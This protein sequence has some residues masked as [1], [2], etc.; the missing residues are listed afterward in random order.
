VRALVVHPGPSFSVHDVWRGWCRGLA[1]NGVETR[2]FRLDDRITFYNYLAVQVEGEQQALSEELCL[3]LVAEDLRAC[4][5]AW[6]PDLVLIV[7]GFF[8][9]HD[10]LD[11]IRH[12]HRHVV[13]LGTESPYE[14]ERQLRDAQHVDLTLV[15][16]PTN[17]DEFRAVGPAEYQPHCYDPTVHRPGPVDPE[18]RSDVA[19][20]GTG[21]PSR[22]AF[23]EQVGFGDLDVLLAGNWTDLPDTSPLHRYLATE[24]EFC[25]DNDDTVRI[26]RSTTVGLN[27][28]RR[29]MT[30]IVGD[31]VG[32]CDGWSMGPR[33]VEL[34]ATGRFFL[35]D[36]RPEGDEVFPFLP[37]F[38]TPA[39]L[40]ELCHHWAARP[41][42]ADE[43]GAK[44]AAAVQDRSF[45]EAAARLLHR[46]TG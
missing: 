34:A 8:L 15:N 40:G 45:P 43:L 17:L 2:P 33:E 37:T 25:T 29:E 10:T 23:L 12:R 41:D 27:L 44:A 46:L 4:C 26:Y 20:V 3:R 24:P 38:T 21:Y 31:T 16:D 13:L 22:R 7:S 36:P 19:F 6:W 5:Y 1:A 14:D 42:E 11:L 30:S 32:H 9:P 18:L 39:E 28:Y 35:R